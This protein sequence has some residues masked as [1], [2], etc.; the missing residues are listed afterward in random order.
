MDSSILKKLKLGSKMNCFILHK[1]DA[2]PSIPNEQGVPPYDYIHLFCHN[3]AELEVAMQQLLTLDHEKSVVWISYPKRSS[4]RASDI[5]HDYLW[6]LM[7]KFQYYP[8]LQIDLDDT[9]FGVRIKKNNANKPYKY[10]KTKV[11]KAEARTLSM[12]EYLDSLAP[13]HK[14]RIQMITRYLAQAYPQYSQTMYTTSQ[15]AFPVYYKNSHC[16]FGIATR[17]GSISI[18][19][20]SE[21]AILY[22]TEKNPRIKRGKGCVRIPDTIEFPDLKKVIDYTFEG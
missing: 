6:N 7:Y 18:Y 22:A 1:P 14:E 4:G 15:N 20:T 19:S 8:M 17:K 21:K 5:H 9:W 3:Q 16:C 12:N 2:F 11:K 13:M 10:P